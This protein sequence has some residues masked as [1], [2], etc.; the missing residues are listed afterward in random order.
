MNRF[1]SILLTLAFLVSGSAGAGDL[2]L[3]DRAAAFGLGVA[4]KSAEK[5]VQLDTDKRAKTSPGQ[6]ENIRR[7]TGAVLG[8]MHRISTGLFEKALGSD[9]NQHSDK[10]WIKTKKKVEKTKFNAKD[11][12]RAIQPLLKGELNVTSHA[13]QPKGRKKN[14]V[15]SHHFPASSYLQ[16]L[17][18]NKG[19][20]VSIVMSKDRHARTRT[21]GKEI[22][23]ESF[24]DSLARD[25]KDIRRIYREDNIDSK[26]VN[27]KMKEA[28]LLNK[29]KYQNELKR[30]SAMRE[31]TVRLKKQANQV[32]VK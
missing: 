3:F 14:G 21:Y 5:A 31:A 2:G 23:G 22:K 9:T 20:G 11:P 15:E 24:R 7:T 1:A 8:G 19:S 6:A 17:G 13:K 28:I 30:D 29:Q 4:T 26:L 12:N 18:L 27:S 32:N 10:N 25:I 16:K